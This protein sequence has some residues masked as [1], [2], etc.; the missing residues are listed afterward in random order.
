MPIP[1]HGAIDEFTAELIGFYAAAEASLYRQMARRI[2]VGI[3]DPGWEQRQVGELAAFRRDIDQ[4]VA[5]LDRTNDTQ[6]PRIISKVSARANAIT[7]QEI[8]AV[9]RPVTS[10]ATASRTAGDFDVADRDAAATQIR[11]AVAP[12]AAR[13]AFVASSTYQNVIGQLLAADLG[14]RRRVAQHALN[15]FATKG[16]TGFRDRAGRSWEM[17]SYVEMAS[18]TIAANH[19]IGVQATR[20]AAAGLDLV[21]VSNAPQE[22]KL[23]RPFEGKIL[24]LSG[25][26]VGDIEA[27]N[28]TTGQP[29]RVRVMTSMAR[30]TAAGL[31]HPNCRHSES[32]YLPGVTQRPTATADVEGDADRQKLRYLERQKRAW[33][34]RASVAL[35]PADAKKA[36][37]AISRYNGLI[38]EHVENTT[39]KRQ[40]SREQITAAR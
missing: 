37:D 25:Q 11:A 16:I 1:E 32:T 34:R 36:K 23:C 28:P 24:S 27:I 29:V 8:G 14:S 13:M 3:D 18:R 31:H 39:A 30:A 5:R 12:V 6:L 4:I 26:N 21:I 9:D 40:R 38:G 10:P 15:V 20:L 22:C 33:L 19:Q 17:A 35:T 7:S 2:Q